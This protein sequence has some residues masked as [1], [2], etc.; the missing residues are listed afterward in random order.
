MTCV[1]F[2]TSGRSAESCSIVCVLTKRWSSW[3]SP[4]LTSMLWCCKSLSVLTTSVPCCLTAI[5]YTWNEQRQC[6]TLRPDSRNH[7]FDIPQ[8]QL[9]STNLHMC[10]SHAEGFFAPKSP[11]FSGNFNSLC[12]SLKQVLITILSGSLCALHTDAE[13]GSAQR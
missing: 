1:F 9:F 6:M 11:F 4:L 7:F 12:C 3:P 13:L 8:A 2:V 10:A 5:K